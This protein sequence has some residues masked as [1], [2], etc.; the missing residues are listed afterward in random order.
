M[1]NGPMMDCHHGLCLHYKITSS[2]VSYA[3][4][5][6]TN[7]LLSLFVVKDIGGR[8]ETTNNKRGNMFVNVSSLKSTERSQASKIISSINIK[9]TEWGILQQK[10]TR[11]VKL[12]ILVTQEI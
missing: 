7:N 6:T 3:P 10:I 9:C 1:Y 12:F 5:G 4:P 2:A 11:I 8:D